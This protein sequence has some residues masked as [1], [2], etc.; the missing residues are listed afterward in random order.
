MDRFIDLNRLAHAGR[1]WTVDLEAL[2][3]AERVFR[4][5]WE[6]CGEVDNGGFEQYFWNSSGETSSLVVGAL[7]DIGAHAAARIVTRALAVFPG[8]APPR[9]D[10]PRRALVDSLTSEQRQ[11]LEECDRAFYRAPDDIT[12]LLLAYVRA[13]AR[14]IEGAAAVDE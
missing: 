2:S 14:E 4:S 7:E 12:G 10:E 11:I 8:S 5:V 3:V 6:L 1:F 13:H 9:A